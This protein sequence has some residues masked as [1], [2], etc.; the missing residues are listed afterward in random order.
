MRIVNIHKWVWHPILFAS[1]IVLALYA[2]NLGQVIP[3]VVFRPLILTV[4]FGLILLGL[5]WLLVKNIHL[6]GIMATWSLVL[7]AI[8][9]RLYE[10]LKSLGWGAS[11][12]RHRYL[13]PL[14]AILF[15][16][17]MFLLLRRRKQKNYRLATTVLNTVTIALVLFSLFSIAHYSI[18][19][20]R[21]AQ[22]YE[23]SV[24]K[25]DISLE[26]PEERPD[27]YYILLDGYTRADVL[28]A[29]YGFDNKDFLQS[30]EELGFYV[31]DCS[32]SNYHHTHL[33]LPTMLN[34]GY[35][36][37][38][39]DEIPE[40]SNL[41]D[42][43]LEHLIKNN[44]VMELFKSVGYKTI[45][46]ET[47]FYW[48]NIE[49]TD[50]YFRATNEAV[51]TTSL[52]PLEDMYLDTTIL[53]AI[54]DLVLA[55]SKP[56]LQAPMMATEVHNVQVNFILDKLKTLHEIEGSTFTFA[57]LI[58]PHPPFIFTEAGAIS[59]LNQYNED[60]EW[61]ETGHEGYL[62]N[63]R[64]INKEIMEVVEAILARSNT[65]PVIIIQGDH[66]APFNDRSMILSAYFA[67]GE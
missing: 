34:M 67:R 29:R 48:S 61:G 59:N 64:F 51:A 63:I 25:S 42:L 23:S 37:D 46:F 58:V 50:L 49:D 32:R 26:V 20:S 65:D 47:N 18:N 53:K 14:W 44:R 16:S 27:V 62:N 9:G 6:A 22:N 1:Y 10:F 17:G 12:A 19:K 11:I 38:L 40:D 43:P 35:L 56:G 45:S 55:S 13:L 52:S 33:S 60:D 54:F 4:L 66:G 39:L 2:H 3:S 24:Q 41:G 36:E 57:H 15:L 31:A 28:M 21:T 5:Y 30:L 7:F 8:Y